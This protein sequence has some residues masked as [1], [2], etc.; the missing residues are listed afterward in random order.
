M[1][2]ALK[3]NLTYQQIS[4]ILSNLTVWLRDIVLREASPPKVPEGGRGRRESI[5]AC[6]PK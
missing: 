2:F 4:T 3:G 1:D 6:T 5:P